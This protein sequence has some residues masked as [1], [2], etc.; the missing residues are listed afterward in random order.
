MQ[1]D[2]PNQDGGKSRWPECEGQ[3][4]EDAEILIKQD[5]PD[6]TVERLHAGSDMTPPTAVTIDF[7]PTRVRVYVNDAGLVVGVPIVG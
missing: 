3:P 1:I 7:R 4:F 2:L 5:F 6:A